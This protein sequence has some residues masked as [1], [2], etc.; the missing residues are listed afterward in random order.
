MFLLL[1]SGGRD[2][3]AAFGGNVLYSALQA[4]AN[5]A[6]IIATVNQ[7]FLKKVA[8]FDDNLHHVGDF[9]KIAGN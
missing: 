7:H 6:G 4:T 1:Q 8:L 5:S 2:G 9:I 3:L